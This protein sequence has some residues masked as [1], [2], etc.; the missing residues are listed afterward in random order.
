MKKSNLFGYLSMIAC[1]IYLEYVFGAAI[2]SDY[3]YLLSGIKSSG[4]IESKSSNSIGLQFKIKV[5]TKS[6]ERD[7]FFFITKQYRTLNI[8]GNVGDT[9]P[10]RYL[11]NNFVNI[12]IGKFSFI[13]FFFTNLIRLFE[14]I[15]L[16]ILS[17]STYNY[18]KKKS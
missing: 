9:L 5:L 7:T 2:N 3:K 17:K 13:G 6:G 16:I 18:I 8:S 11:K 15:L 12:S 4:I 1:F 14:V 10:V